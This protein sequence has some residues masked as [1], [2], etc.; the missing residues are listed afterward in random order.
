MRTLED[1]MS[2]IPKKSHFGWGEDRTSIESDK[3]NIIARLS[4]RCNL[5]FP[6]FCEYILGCK[7][8]NFHKEPMQYI[9]TNRFILIVWPRGHLKTTIWSE[10]YPIWRLWK[11]TGI[12][13]A[14]TS[15][16]LEQSQRI[17]EDIQTKIS[18]N[19]FLRELVPKNRSDSWNKSQLNT[20]NK[21][22]CY[23]KPFN[24]T[25]RGT[26]ADYLIID[27][28]LREENLSQE[29]LKDYFWSIF[30]PT[31]QTRGGQIIVVGTPMTTKDLFAELA[32]N[33]EWKSIKK[34]CVKVDVSGKWIEPIWKNRF[35]LEE[36]IKIKESQGSLRFEREYMCN[37]LGGGATIFKNIKIGTHEELDKA[38]PNE[39]YFMGCDI[40]M[41]TGVKRDF[42]AFCILGK[43]MK[44]G[45]IKQRKLERY[46]GWGEDEIIK[47]IIELNHKFHFKKVFMENIGLSVG[48][49]KTFKR[50]PD[51]QMEGFLTNRAG[52]EAL[53]SAINVGFETGILE[54]LDNTIQYNELIAFKAKE[55]AR[56]GKVTY[57]GVGEHD[58]TVIAL[59]LA[60]EAIN[61]QSKGRASI[62]FV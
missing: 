12:E 62:T 37:P 34:A 1:I 38:L 55:D 35:T 14:I 40:A 50:I 54:I 52:K 31:V 30:F 11:E 23:Q 17:I 15:S 4:A 27:D 24:S 9:S 39:D 41:Q 33:K 48:L 19:E 5:D 45:M 10:A 32:E 43:D 22:K 61:S 46:K 2:G 42:L 36:L 16:A 18:D 25:A 57:E 20:E 7:L 28:I 60:M 49:V 8:D 53:I 13:I 3:F 59:G 21:N 56:S 58:D 29:Q 44:T 6:F 47:R 51:V 26:H